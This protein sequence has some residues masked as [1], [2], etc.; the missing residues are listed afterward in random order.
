MS[1]TVKNNL[2]ALQ[3][4]NAMNK[5]FFALS[6]SL[7]KVS[8]GQKINSAKDDAS[9]YVI[10]EKMREQIRS[11]SQDSQNVQNGT[12]L[13]K[14]AEG[15]IN[16][17]VEELRN[18]KELAINAAN[19]TNTDTDRV[20]IQK[21]FNQ[22]M[23]NINDIA[24]TTNYNGKTLLDGTYY[25]KFFTADFPPTPVSGENDIYNIDTDGYYVL[26]K[27]FTGTVNVNAQNVRITQEDPTTALN[28][29]TILGRQEGNLNLWIDSLNITN[30]DNISI[31]RFNGSENVLTFKGTS[32]LTQQGDDINR[33]AINVGQGL[34]H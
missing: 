24:T 11:L 5:N 26:P 30:T 14:I 10:S 2:A 7:V 20:T 19:D 1:T 12:S 4:L 33:A 22:K 34:T 8:S 27:G 28:N 15:G 3:T 31:I 13:F 29:V 16:S 6:K 23:A 32:R 18:L 21:V 25:R 17:I 9:S